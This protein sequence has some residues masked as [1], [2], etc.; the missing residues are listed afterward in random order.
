MSKHS[1]LIAAIQETKLKK[2][3]N[4]SDSFGDFSILRD[5]RVRNT[6]GGLCFFIH[7]SVKYQ[8]LELQQPANDSFLEQQGITIFSGK[9]QLKLFNIY[10][11]PES[12]CEPGYL[13]SIELQLK[14]DDATNCG[15]H[16]A[17][18]VGLSNFDT[19]NEDTPTR[20]TNNC[21]SLRSFDHFRD[22]HHSL[23]YSKLDA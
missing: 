6:G 8:P 23:W 7:N 18:Q 21:E 14:L 2:K 19:I 10:I 4:F 11:P 12:C 13:P 3:S 16:S 9:T 5:D 1:I 15:I 17:E 20:V 22:N